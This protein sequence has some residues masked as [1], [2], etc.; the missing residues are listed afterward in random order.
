MIAIVT[1]LFAFPLGFFL[2]NRVSA[3]IA[4]LAI[5]SYTYTFQTMTLLREQLNGSK[6]FPANPNQTAWSYL[7]V[8]AGIL[9]IGFGLVTFAHHLATKRRARTTTPLDLDA[10]H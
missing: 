8:T 10:A 7:V 2:R 4:Y 9:V 5:Y 6:I 3:Y 1:V